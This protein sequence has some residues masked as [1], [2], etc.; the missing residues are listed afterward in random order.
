[1]LKMKRNTKCNAIIAI[2]KIAINVSRDFQVCLS[3][4]GVDD[5]GRIMFSFFRIHLKHE[6]VVRGGFHPHSS[7]RRHSQTRTPT[8]ASTNRRPPCIG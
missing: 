5:A 1:M 3:V 8:S 4:C 2:A 7:L 6:K